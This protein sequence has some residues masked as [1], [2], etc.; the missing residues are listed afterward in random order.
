MYRTYVWDDSVYNIRWVYYSTNMYMYTLWLFKYIILV[1]STVV[2]MYSTIV[3]KFVQHISIL[4]LVGSV[5]ICR[6]F[7]LQ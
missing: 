1:Y 2:Y 7:L 6:I 3:C 4:A 5:R